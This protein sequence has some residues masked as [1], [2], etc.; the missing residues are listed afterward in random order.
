METNPTNFFLPHAFFL[1]LITLA[2]LINNTAAAALNDSAAAG[3]SSSSS[4]SCVGSI[5]ECNQELEMLMESEISRRILEQKKY[6]S[7]GALKRDQ[8]VCNGGEAGEPYSRGSGCLPDPS[9]TYNR[10]C[11][12]Y[13]RCRSDA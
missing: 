8:P 5:A 11:S 7:P 9:N 4:S 13:Y 3:P 12:R 2:Y 6:I 1:L 10:G